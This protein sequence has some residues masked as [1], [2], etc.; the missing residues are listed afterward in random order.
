MQLDLNII[1]IL[2]KGSGGGG[3]SPVNFKQFYCRGNLLRLS[4]NMCILFCKDIVHIYFIHEI[5]FYNIS[6]SNNVTLNGKL[7]AI[8]QFQCDC[9]TYL[10]IVY[11]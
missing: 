8:I 9:Y 6:C 10:D 7:P 5:K 3:G 11:S 1:L 4:S 2:C